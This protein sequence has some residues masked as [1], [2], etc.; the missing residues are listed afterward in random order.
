[1]RIEREER[2]KKRA[3]TTQSQSRTLENTVNGH[4]ESMKRLF[5]F[6]LKT[7]CQCRVFAPDQH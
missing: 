5:M 1:M 3:D 4:R 2:V 6:Y 7:I